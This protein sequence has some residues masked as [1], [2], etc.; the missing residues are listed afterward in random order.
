MTND[1]FLR[2]AIVA[3]VMGALPFLRLIVRR[4]YDKWRE[5][6]TKSRGK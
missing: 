1:E 6:S 5:S 4:W 2:G 3:T